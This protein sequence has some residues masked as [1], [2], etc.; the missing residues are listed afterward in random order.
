MAV[1]EWAQKYPFS[2]WA[3]FYVGWG[4]SLA[5]IAA[6]NWL[7]YK[8][9]PKRVSKTP[10]GFALE[11]LARFGYVGLAVPGIFFPLYVLGA[12]F[13]PMLKRQEFMIIT[14]V[15]LVTS[16]LIL[17]FL[18]KRLVDNNTAVQTQ[19]SINGPRP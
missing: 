4:Y 2:F 5:A 9:Y 8:C 19:Q 17:Y 6:I 15:T 1:S 3:F 18:L 16:F 7:I 12:F 10:L 11:A 13:K 14:G